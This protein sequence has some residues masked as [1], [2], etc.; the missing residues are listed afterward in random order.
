MPIA[1]PASMIQFYDETIVAD[2]VSDTGEQAEDLEENAKL[3]KLLSA[4]Q[5]RL[6]SAC[7]VAAI[8]T[9]ES[10]A[11]MTG[12][13]L[14]L[15]EEIICG[16]TMAAL[17]RRRPGRYSEIAEQVKDYEDYL[18]RLRKGER[19]FGGAAENRAASLPDVDG[20]TV[21]TYQRMNLMIDRTR[22][23]PSRGSRLPLGRS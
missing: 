13:S 6:E 1:T 23:Y 4:A 3:S 14:A 21:A 12:T 2:L 10:L 16:L 11:A 7:T 5:G 15:L 18:D 19:I 20:P 22:F 17:L 8:Y 9:P